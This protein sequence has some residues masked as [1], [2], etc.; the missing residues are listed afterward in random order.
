MSRSNPTPTNPA[1][2]FFSWAGGKG[3]LQFYDKEKKE[4]I[5]VPLPM[6]F[7]V[8]DELATMTGYNKKLESGYW[9]NEV[10]STKKEE[11]I[12]RTKN[13]IAQSGLY[14]QLAD[15]RGKGAKYA[16]S[17]YF[18]H[19]NSAGD[20]II[21]NFQAAGSALSAWIDFGNNHVPT[22]GKVRISRGEKQDSPV[23][24]FYPPAFTFLPSTPEEDAEAIRLDKEL[25]IYLNQY[26]AAAEYNRTNQETPEDLS[27]V[28]Y[29]NPNDT[30]DLMKAEVD[31]NGKKH[32]PEP[33]IVDNTDMDKPIDLSEIPF[34]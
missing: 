16:K 25:Q 6:E 27:T 1:Q 22:N 32:A 31:E 30:A 18:A 3:Q 10:R 33:R 17:I 34:N 26:L 19:R 28:P 20:Y 21:G 29:V 7:L 8:L 13:G 11:F 2:H 9:S 14:E 23:G 4:N 12:V 24:D 5:A 15:V